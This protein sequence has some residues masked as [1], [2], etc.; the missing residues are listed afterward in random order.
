MKPPGRSVEFS[1]HINDGQNGAALLHLHRIN[2]SKRG[3]K[4][5]NNIMTRVLF[6][7]KRKHDYSALAADANVLSVSTGLYNS[8]NYMVELLKPMVDEVG[9]VVVTDNNDIDREV[10]KFNPTHVIIEA[11]WV[12][13]EKFEVLTKLHPKVQWIVRLHSEVPFIASEGI[14]M[15]WIGRYLDYPNVLIGVNAP[16][17]LQSV[18]SF[19]KAKT[20]Y[21]SDDEI[22]Q[23]TI[24]MPNYYPV[25]GA[26]AYDFSTSPDVVKI[27]CFGAVRPLKNQ[28]AQALA[29][30]EFAKSHGKGLEFHIN[31]S[32]VE[33]NGSPILKNLVQMFDHL[34]PRYVLV[35]HEWMP[36]EEFLKVVGSMD[37]LMQVS[38]SET[39]NIVAADATVMGVPVVGS[40][41]IPW[42]CVFKADPTSQTSMIRALN[43]ASF[44]P[45]IAVL[46]NQLSLRRYDRKTK[47]VWA[48]LFAEPSPWKYFLWK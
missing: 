26:K 21:L 47:Q 32:R 33:M 46:L 28:L 6:I 40:S 48:N 25:E 16:R 11:L 43:W 39:F 14:S 22:F 4:V 24:Y 36:R 15:D 37:I 9:I 2:K 31:S 44:V 10:R 8:A 5:G 35:C 42:L 45:S 23:R 20:G 29:A 7:L 13:P 1:H 38:F 27:G 3:S 17:M 18:R 41:E 12:V 19:L 34:G 30:V